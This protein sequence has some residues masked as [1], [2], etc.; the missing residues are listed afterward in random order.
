MGFSAEIPINPDRLY[1]A[2]NSVPSVESI[3]LMTSSEAKM[4]QN[5]RRSKCTT[6]LK[7][8]SA[9]SGLESNYNLYRLQS[10]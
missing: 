6:F 5:G 2:D 1:Y 9:L 3:K 4:G 7:K 10:Y 8:L